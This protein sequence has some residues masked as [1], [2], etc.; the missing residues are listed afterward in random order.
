MVMKKK[1]NILI[2]GTLISLFY[3]CSNKSSN[4]F[5][6]ELIPVKVSE[7]WGYVNAEGKYEINPQFSYAGFFI[8]NVALV[9]CQV[10]IVG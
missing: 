6:P 8:D 5:A 9:S 4:D 1:I 2:L 10:K 3:S 7:K